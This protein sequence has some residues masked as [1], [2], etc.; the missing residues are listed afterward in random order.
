MKSTGLTLETLPHRRRGVY[1]NYRT[2]F[3][4]FN[5]EDTKDLGDNVKLSIRE[6]QKDARSGY[7]DNFYLNGRKV[8]PEKDNDVCIASFRRRASNRIEGGKQLEYRF[9]ALHCDFRGK[10]DPKISDKERALFFKHIKHMGLFFGFDTN[11]IRR[12]AVLFVDAEKHTYQEIFMT[13]CLLRAV[14]DDSKVVR[15]FNHLVDNG[16]D[17]WVALSLSKMFT[18]NSGHLFHKANDGLDVEHSSIRVNWVAGLY[19]FVKQAV[20]KKYEPFSKHP[21]PGYVG[22]LLAG[23]VEEV[24]PVEYGKMLTYANSVARSAK[25]AVSRNKYK[26]LH[27]LVEKIKDEE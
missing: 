27:K 21:N 18:H 4:T 9:F 6:K 23:L 3:Y 19:R 5:K 8:I 22:D 26:A 12:K 20:Y 14:G 25:I 24:K 13:Y 1:V 17:K 16:V 10:V 2:N 11:L 7:Y 15:T